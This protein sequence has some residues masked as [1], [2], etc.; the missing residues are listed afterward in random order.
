VISDDDLVG[1]LKAEL[2]KRDLTPG[3]FPERGKPL[4]WPEQKQLIEHAMKH[5]GTGAER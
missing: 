4:P 1:L 3:D 5:S 2:E